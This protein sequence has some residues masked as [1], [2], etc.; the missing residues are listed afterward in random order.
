MLEPTGS[1]CEKGTR[2]PHTPVEL[3][4]L[5]NPEHAEGARFIV[6]RRKT[7]PKHRDASYTTKKCEELFTCEALNT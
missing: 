6:L 2:E 3:H 4:D 7:M 5:K 1:M